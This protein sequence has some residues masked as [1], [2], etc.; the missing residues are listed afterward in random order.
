[1]AK[2]TAV[3]KIEKELEKTAKEISDLE[4]KVN[5]AKKKV[6]SLQQQ[7]FELENEELTKYISGKNISPT[8]VL[9]LLQKQSQNNSSVV[10][11]K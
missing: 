7:K 5:E 3:E 6:E 2:L 10:K 4:N 8:I 11:T 9:E 1:M